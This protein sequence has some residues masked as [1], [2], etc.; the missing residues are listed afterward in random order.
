M[1]RDIEN[2]GLRISL[3]VTLFG[4]PLLCD[5]GAGFFLIRHQ[6]DG[7]LIYAAVGVALSTLSLWFL[8][9]GRTKV[10][11]VIFFRIVSIL[12]AV[13]VSLALWALV[14]ALH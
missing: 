4:L 7:A 13:G 3:G 8:F 9:L 5:L 1:S 14:G 10:D 12:L 6:W 11:E 2:W